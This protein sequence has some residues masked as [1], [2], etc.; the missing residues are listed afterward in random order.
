[1]R[2]KSPASARCLKRSHSG[3]ELSTGDMPGTFSDNPASVPGLSTVKSLV[4]VGSGTK[5]FVSVDIDAVKSFIGSACA[6]GGIQQKA[7]EVRLLA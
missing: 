1:M 2:E 7:L 5:V 3:W 4:D 6:A